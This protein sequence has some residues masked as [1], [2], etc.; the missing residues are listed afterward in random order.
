MGKTIPIKA[1]YESK[2][3]YRKRLQEYLNKYFLKIPI[4]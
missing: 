3:E 4:I 1:P 2:I